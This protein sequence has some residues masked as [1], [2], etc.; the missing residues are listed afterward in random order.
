[1]KKFQ[2]KITLDNFSVQEN[3]SKSKICGFLKELL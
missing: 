2:E 3:I 1:M